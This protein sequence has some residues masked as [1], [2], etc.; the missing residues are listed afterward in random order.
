MNLC[1]GLLHSIPPK[2]CLRISSTLPQVG[3][4]GSTSANA[5][6]DKSAPLKEALQQAWPSLANDQCALLALARLGRS[7]RIRQQGRLFPQ[8]S[9][10]EAGSLWL[11]V[12]GKLSM[13]RYAPN[14]S[15]RQ[16][17]ALHS[18]QW[19]DTASA[20]QRSPFPESGEALTAVLVHEL[21][22]V[23]VLDLCRQ[24]PSILQALVSSLGSWACEAMETRQA[25]ST[26]TFPAR[27]ADWLLQEQKLHGDPESLG[28]GLLKR[29]LA[30]QL[31]VTP[32]TLSRTL[33]LFQE[34]GLISM[35]GRSIRLLD[36]VR[37]AALSG[38]LAHVA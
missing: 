34:Q 7:H 33:R 14:G 4:R 5:P 12:R 23:A 37:L 20:W 28:L 30:A 9:H 13:G 3:L 2:P 36:P 17:R 10:N 31:S 38:Q 29:D 19:I 16:S 27:L 18:G 15:W 22:S 8:G 11:L 6:T 32:E 21:S 1:T 35:Q 25:L 26:Q 24:H